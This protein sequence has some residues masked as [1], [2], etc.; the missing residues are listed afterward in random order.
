VLLKE[1]DMTLKEEADKDTYK[2]QIF[3][4]NAQLKK[5]LDKKFE[6]D[7]L[8]EA[9][10]KEEREKQWKKRTDEWDREQEARE[11]LLTEVY[12]DRGMQV[13][14]KKEELEARKLEF[15]MQRDAF[16]A[17][18][19]RQEDLEIEKQE[20]E[21]RM[22]ILHQEEL[23]KQMDYKQV[24]KDREHAQQEYER[25]EAL[26]QE[27]KFQAAID[28]EKQKQ[29]LIAMEIQN[30]RGKSSAAIIAPWDK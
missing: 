2:R 13:Q 19:K 16:L 8:L 27:Q 23:F 26:L 10:Q 7:D 6:S 14:M 15:E 22:K 28:I 9:L 3:E 21:K 17:E 12:E 1:R 5:Q 25:R 20:H 4:F 11:K 29:R 24:M 30:K 18:M